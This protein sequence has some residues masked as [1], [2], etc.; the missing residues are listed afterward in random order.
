M[1]H[2]KQK[3]GQIFGSLALAALI[4]GSGL[5]LRRWKTHPTATERVAILDVPIDPLTMAQALGR[6]DEFIRSRAPHH[7]FTADAS[8]IMRAQDEPVLLD[9]VQQADMVTPDGAGVMLAS[10]L[11]GVQLPERVSGVDLVEAISALAAQRGYRIYLFGAADGVAQS[12]ADT[13][14]ARYAGLTIAGTR[15]GFFAAEEAGAI[16]REIAETKPDALFVGLGIPKQEQFI[17]T[18]FHTLGV[19]VMIGIG[20]SFDVI[21]GR[22]QRAPRWMQRTGLEWLYRFAQEPTRLPRL[23]ALPQFVI[24]AW[25]S[26]RA[27]RHNG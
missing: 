9:I 18:H 17:R 8:G 6:I 10:H 19:P 24:A 5:L 13:L 2:D 22:L 12:A 27:T 20:G 26:A 7:I 23:A 21:S 1:A 4:V 3:T 11:H 25:R 15:H 14:Q 16:A